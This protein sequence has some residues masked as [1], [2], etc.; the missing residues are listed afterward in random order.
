MTLSSLSTTPCTN[1]TSVKQS[2]TLELDTTFLSHAT[3]VGN[4]Y[5][6]N[7]SLMA[8][9]KS[10]SKKDS[11]TRKFPVSTANYMTSCAFLGSDPSCKVDSN[12]V[13]SLDVLDTSN[14][15]IPFNMVKSITRLTH[16]DSLRQSWT[17]SHRNSADNVHRSI[18]SICSAI[19][20]VVFTKQNFRYSHTTR[21]IYIDIVGS[22]ISSVMLSKTL[23][24]NSIIEHTYD[25]P[26]FST[27]TTKDSKN[28]N[29]DIKIE[30]ARSRTSH[31]KIYPLD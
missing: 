22:T 30:Y 7:T 20:A 24:T 27:T 29:N 6:S 17:N 18:F 26:F 4:I 25:I 19:S 31:P 11:N 8:A 28:G 1:Q 14:G 3:I 2:I 9:G 16:K 13:I 15:K 5:A 21:S 23:T 12:N 10:L